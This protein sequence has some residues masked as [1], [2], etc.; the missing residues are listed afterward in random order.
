L[1]LYRARLCAAV[2]AVKQ[3]TLP[4]HA[5]GAAHRGSTTIGTILSQQQDTAL[6]CFRPLNQKT[7]ACRRGAARLS[8]MG[9]GRVV[10]D[11]RT[12][13]DLQP[14]GGV[15]FKENTGSSKSVALARY[16]IGVTEF[17]GCQSPTWCSS[18]FGLKRRL[19]TATHATAP[20]SGENPPF[21]KNKSL[22]EIIAEAGIFT[23][24]A[25]RP[26]HR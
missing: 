18:R 6:K 13:C 10:Y 7:N 1:W 19:V 12:G 9:A 23:E 21:S 25:E 22:P 16:Q 20:H 15:Q 26:P 3:G 4:L 8:S 11:G 17:P 2:T 14:M 24:S 5:R